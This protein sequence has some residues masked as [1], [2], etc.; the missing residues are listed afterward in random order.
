[1][2]IYVG[3]NQLL[4]KIDGTPL[5]KKYFKEREE[6]KQLFNKFKKGNLQSSLIFSRDF[7][8]IY[9]LSKTSWMD[10]PP[11]AIPL[12]AMYSDEFVD[13]I[14][15]R[16]SPGP[17]KKTKIGDVWP[18]PYEI[19]GDIYSIPETKIDLAWFMIKMSVLFKKGVLKLVDSNVEISLECDN[20]VV[21]TDV[22]KA[23]FSDSLTEEQCQLIY[24]LFKNGKFSYNSTETLKSNS[25]SLWKIVS[26]STNGDDMQELK[27]VIDSIIKP[28][29]ESSDN[30]VIVEGIEYPLLDVPEGWTKSDILKEAESYKIEVPKKPVKNN[31]L[32][33]IVKA[34]IGLLQPAT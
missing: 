29:V 4:P 3:L 9:N 1:M 22:A 23:L 7:K 8:K 5:E 18:K 33:T 30:T 20:I 21:Q 12:K 34:K 24:A 19:I 13:S 2:A 27:T 6:I 15:V 10:A 32:Y 28:V 17:P 25:L 11:L 16:Y 31:V 26:G 14:E